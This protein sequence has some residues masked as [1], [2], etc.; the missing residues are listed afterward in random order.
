VPRQEWDGVQ[1]RGG[2]CPWYW[3]DGVLGRVKQCPVKGWIVSLAEVGWCPRQAALFV[4][5]NLCLIYLV[6]IHTDPWPATHPSL[7]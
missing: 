1:G 4:C 3:W 2:G 5:L 6:F 7:R